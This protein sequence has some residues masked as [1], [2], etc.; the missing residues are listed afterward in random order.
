MKDELVQY[1]LYYNTERPHQGLG[2]KTP[3]ETM[4]NLSA[5]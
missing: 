4:Q 2:G 1:L 3:L 5:N